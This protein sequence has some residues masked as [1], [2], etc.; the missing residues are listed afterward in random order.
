MPRVCTTPKRTVLRMSA[1][2][3]KSSRR[4]Y[5]PQSEI[6]RP[7]HLQAAAGVSPTTAWRMRQRGEFPEPLELTP[8]A[9]GW[10]RADIAAWL[11]S[12]PRSGGA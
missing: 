1:T 6:I 8:G 2:A 12:R 10:R 9:K 3:T 7:R 4:G 5:D 11:E